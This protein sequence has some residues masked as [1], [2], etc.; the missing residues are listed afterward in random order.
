MILFSSSHF[1]LKRLFDTISVESPTLTFSGQKFFF[2]TKTMML[3]LMG[4]I[5]TFELVL[6]DE[7]KEEKKELCSFI[8]Y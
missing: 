1:Q 6:L 5:V 2:I 7:I 8:D 4:A 3:T